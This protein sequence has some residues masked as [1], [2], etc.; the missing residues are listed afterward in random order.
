VKR[1]TIYDVKITLNCEEFNSTKIPREF[2]RVKNLR[3]FLAKFDLL[4]DFSHCYRV[5]RLRNGKMV[6][7]DSH[8]SF[9]RLADHGD[10]LRGLAP[11]QPTINRSGSL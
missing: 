11:R 8:Y 9:D 4:N 7:L 6:R 1:K 3:K 5:S 10:Y 2:S